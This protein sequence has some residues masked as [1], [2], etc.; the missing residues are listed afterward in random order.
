LIKSFEYLMD[1]AHSFRIRLKDF[2]S[3]S[4]GKGKG[5]KKEAAPKAVIKPSHATVYVAKKF[6]Q[7]QELILKTLQ[8]MY[9]TSKPDL[10]E[11]KLIAGALGKITE[12]KK[13]MKKV[14]PFVDER[15][16]MFARQGESVFCQTSEFDETAV[17]Q[18]NIEYLTNTLELEGITISFADQCD[19]P[20]IQEECCPLE[21]SIIYR[22]ESSVQVNLLNDQPH[23]GLFNVE[24]PVYDGD[25][26]SKLIARV[27]K[28]NRLKDSTAVNLLRYVDDKALR[29]IPSMDNL[30]DGKEPISVVAKFE[31]VDNGTSKKLR[32][33]ENN[34]AY[35][36]DL[37]RQLIYRV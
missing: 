20:H 2:T 25:S 11:N 5:G 37:V 9:V 4:A 12:L 1:T 29:G 3:K 21:P 32:V 18:D 34:S 26:V 15:K 23:S 36:I 6:P 8:D 24:V 13:Y 22:N 17:L 16:K 10:P 31:L 19:L 30:S 33:A 7:W 14:M 35:D 27:V 28:E